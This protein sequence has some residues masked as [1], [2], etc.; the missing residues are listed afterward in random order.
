MTDIVF[1]NKNEEKFIE[2]AERIGTKEVYFIYAYQKN[3]GELKNKIQE[4]QKAT[5]VKLNLGLIAGSKDILKAKRICNFVIAESSDDDQHVLE[6]LT[7]SLMLNFEKS[8]KRDR[9]HYRVSGLNQVLCK[10][11]AKNEVVIGFSFSELLN[12]P[13]FKRAVLLGR[14]M[15]NIRL[16]RKYKVKTLLASFAKTSFEMRDERILKSLYSILN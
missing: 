14:M 11:A 12:A 15:Q 3:I 5:K 8:E 9:F 1:P 7:P 4:L 2:T 16:C 10:L 6:K 13:K